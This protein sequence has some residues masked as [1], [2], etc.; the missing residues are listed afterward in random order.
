VHAGLWLNA[1]FFVLDLLYLGK[2]CYKDFLQNGGLSYVDEIVALQ[3]HGLLDPLDATKRIRVEFTWSMDGAARGELTAT[4]KASSTYPL[5]H[6]TMTQLQSRNLQLIGGVT[7]TVAQMKAAEPARDLPDSQRSAHARKPENAGV[8]GANLIRCPMTRLLLEVLHL[9]LRILATILQQIVRVLLMLGCDLPEFCT[10]LTVCGHIKSRIVFIGKKGLEVCAAGN[11]V[12]KLL[13]FGD[14]LLRCDRNHAFLP[15]G[16]HA[17]AVIATLRDI[18]AR[19]V[20]VLRLLGELDPKRAVADV[21]TFAREALLLGLLCTEAFGS[22]CITPSFRNLI[23]I[24]PAQMRVRYR[25]RVFVCMYS[26]RTCMTS[27]LC[28]RP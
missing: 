28:S 4:S 12:R 17:A 16:P 3:E 1:D 21:D 2:D 13:A 9:K 23:D 20:R 14:G 27:F 26:A 19:T 15:T 25:A 11:E 5:Q 24:A 7:R 6:N 18:W 22:R 10:H 8:V